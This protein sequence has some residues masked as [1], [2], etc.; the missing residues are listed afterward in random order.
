[1]SVHR[2]SPYKLKPRGSGG[3]ISSHFKNLRK[4]VDSARNLVASEH[5]DEVE[6]VARGSNVLLAVVDKRG[7]LHSGKDATESSGSGH[8]LYR[9]QDPSYLRQRYYVD[10]E[11][12]GPTIG[13]YHERLFEAVRKAGKRY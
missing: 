12:G 10:L 1:M 13:Q 6:I 8:L 7:R 11:R 2:Y 5:Y 4:A 9:D 3:L